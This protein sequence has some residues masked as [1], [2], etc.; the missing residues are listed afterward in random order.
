[1]QAIDLPALIAQRRDLETAIATWLGSAVQR[2]WQ[3]LLPLLA[4]LA[5]LSRH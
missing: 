2:S 4:A 5:G 1:L 3:S